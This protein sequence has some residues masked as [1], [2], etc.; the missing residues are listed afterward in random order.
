MDEISLSSVTHIAEL[1]ENKIFNFIFNPKDYGYE[2]IN[3]EDIIGKGPEYNAK[4]F[5]DM[6]NAPN[7]SFQKIVEINAGAALYLAGQVKN[8]KDGF[9]LANKT[10]NNYQSKK[11]IE[12]LLRNQ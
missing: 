4:V 10:I 6:L 9:I 11:Y 5:I 2:F 1:K 8:L 3:N 7:N 12:N